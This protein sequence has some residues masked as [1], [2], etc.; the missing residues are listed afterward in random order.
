MTAFDI[1]SSGMAAHRAEMDLIAQNIAHAGATTAS[2][3][4]YRERR[5]VFEPADDGSFASAFS[6]AASALRDVDPIEP[7][8]EPLGGVRYAGY[9]EGDASSPD[10]DPIVQMVSLV[11]AGRA[12]DA[13]VAALI[14]AHSLRVAGSGLKD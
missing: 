10:V 14:D 9:V 6:D 4:Q 1:A 2:G 13:D 3:A 5:A 12:Y 8:D 7:A 11:A